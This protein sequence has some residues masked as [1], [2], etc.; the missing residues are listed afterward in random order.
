MM[1]VEQRHPDTLLRVSEKLRYEIDLSN[2][3]PTPSPHVG[4]QIRTITP[5]DLAGLA[6][7]MLDAY[8]GAIDYEGDHG[9]SSAC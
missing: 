2:P 8:I 7:L 3:V 4:L 6:R 1:L 5:A 9:Y